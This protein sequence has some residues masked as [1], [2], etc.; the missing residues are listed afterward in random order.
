MPIGRLHHVVLDCPDP[1]R[2]AA[3]WSAVLGD[4]VAYDS[5]DWVVVA[6]SDRTS[7]LAFQRAPDH[8]APVWGDP[9]RPQQWH[10]DVMVDDK[11]SARAAVEGLGAV[12][13]SPAGDDADVYADPA[14][15]P[16]CL[17]ARPGWAPPVDP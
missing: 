16:F 6:A 17:I 11:P 9:D 15:H 14:G 10:V 2:L 7:G 13:L 5:D 8:R 3:F 1:R 4:P 12:R